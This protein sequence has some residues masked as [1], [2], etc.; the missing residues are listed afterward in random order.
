MKLYFIGHLYSGIEGRDCQL[1]V[2][3]CL[4]LNTS[5][6]MLTHLKSDNAFVSRDTARDRQCDENVIYADHPALLH[7]VYVI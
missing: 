3:H 2:Y 5:V 6:R 1:N 7:V 4:A